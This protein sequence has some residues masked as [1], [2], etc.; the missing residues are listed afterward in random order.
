MVG[1][2]PMLSICARIPLIF[3]DVRD[4]YAICLR[5]RLKACGVIPI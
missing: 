1:N 2:E 4:C 3:N 5:I